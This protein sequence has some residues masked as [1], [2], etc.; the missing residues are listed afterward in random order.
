MTRMEMIVLRFHFGWWRLD[1]AIQNV[2]LVC[3]SGSFSLFSISLSL[4]VWHSLKLVTAFSHFPSASLYKFRRNEKKKKKKKFLSSLFLS[5][6]PSHKFCCW[7]CDRLFAGRFRCVP[8]KTFYHPP[9]FFYHNFFIMSSYRFSPL[10]FYTLW[11]FFLDK[12]K[13]NNSRHKKKR[14]RHIFAT[15]P[16]H[17]EWK[18]ERDKKLT[19]I[20]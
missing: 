2:C 1:R 13:S 11:F 10:S 3:V 14:Y 12:K 8:H 4:S 15:L 9:R 20:K 16:F 17:F 5:L 18:K 6:S 7:L 19:F